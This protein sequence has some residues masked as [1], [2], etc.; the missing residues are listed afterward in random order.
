MQLLSALLLGISTN[1]DNLFLGMSL[2]VARRRISAGANWLIG[3]FSAGATGLFCC[4]SARCAALGPVVHRVGG[5]LLTA[6]GLWTLL[7]S[8]GADAD[9]CAAQSAAVLGAALAVNC[10]PVALGAG[11]AGIHPLAASVS[12]GLLSV[13]AIRL[14]NWLGLRAAVLSVRAEAL[15]RLG[16]LLLVGLGVL[17]LAA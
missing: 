6:V 3:L 2:G 9:R 13:A 10:I 17:Q 5:G 7:P 12:V 15:Q 1:L 16:G 4:L 11:L 14:G 8:G